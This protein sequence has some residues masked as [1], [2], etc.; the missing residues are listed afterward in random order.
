MST[1]PT[2]GEVALGEGR[3]GEGGNIEYYYCRA[4]LLLFCVTLI[5]RVQIFQSMGLSIKLYENNTSN[6]FQSK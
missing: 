6:K 4:Q 5:S 2:N 1:T 3:G